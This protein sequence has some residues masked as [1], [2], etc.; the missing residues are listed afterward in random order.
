MEGG[1]NF[2]CDCGRAW[3]IGFALD[4]QPQDHWEAQQEGVGPGGEHMV[5]MLDEEPPLM[6]EN[7]EEE[8]Y[9]VEGTG[10]T[11]IKKEQMNESINKET[12]DQNK[13]HG[14]VSPQQ[15]MGEPPAHLLSKGAASSE[16]QGRFD[17]DAFRGAAAK[18]RPKRTGSP[19]MQGLPWRR[20]VF[21]SGATKGCLSLG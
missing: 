4:L 7:S 5:H 13:K 2:T 3:H 9:V 18:A 8:P 19:E 14:V 21:N 6:L 16:G 20:K 1:A 12:M 11:G 17:E 15:P 10:T